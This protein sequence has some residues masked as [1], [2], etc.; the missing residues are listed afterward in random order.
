MYFVVTIGAVIHLH[1]PDHCHQQEVL[2]ECQVEGPAMEWESDLFHDILFF[3]SD[4]EG[5]VKRDGMF[6][7]TLSDRT[8]NSTTCT[9]A[10]IANDALDD[11]TVHVIHC[12]DLLDGQERAC[13]I[14]II[15]MSSN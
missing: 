6:N 7:A 15:R 10:F 11:G 8:D 4:E 13:Y 9:L 5:H 12:Q 3:G 14:N 1:C 2:Y